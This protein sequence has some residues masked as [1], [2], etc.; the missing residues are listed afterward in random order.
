MASRVNC[1]ARTPT[2]E[3]EDSGSARA[4]AAAHRYPATQICNEGWG[5]SAPDQEQ[6]AAGPLHMLSLLP[7]VH[8]LRTFW[9]LFRCHLLGETTLLLTSPISWS[10]YLFTT[11]SSPPTSDTYKEECP[12]HL[13]KGQFSYF[14][15]HP[16]RPLYRWGN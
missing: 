3:R 9:S 12:Q 15:G 1:G 4:E 11:Y 8:F 13:P 5:S 6:S 16:K 14:P 10:T 2:Q 7:Q